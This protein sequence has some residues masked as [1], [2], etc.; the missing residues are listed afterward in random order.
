MIASQRLGSRGKLRLKER[1]G[2]GVSFEGGTL[3]VPFRG[4]GGGGIIKLGLGIMSYVK[5]L[6][7]WINIIMTVKA[8]LVPPP[9]PPPAP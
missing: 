4:V 6:S 8:G 3:F 7:G 5:A 9:P 1:R 2:A